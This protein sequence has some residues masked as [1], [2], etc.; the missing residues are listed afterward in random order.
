MAGRWFYGFLI[1]FWMWTHLL[2]LV[3]LAKYSYLLLF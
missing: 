3:S 1:S 2:F